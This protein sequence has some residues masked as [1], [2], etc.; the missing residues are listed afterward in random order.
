MTMT[1]DRPNR[2]K[3]R[4]PYLHIT[5]LEVRVNERQERVWREDDNVDVLRR[6]FGECN[7]VSGELCCSLD[8]GWI[9]L[10]ITTN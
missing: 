4:L 2:V 7:E 3:G 9:E 1:S 5:I 6:V 8:A 10:P